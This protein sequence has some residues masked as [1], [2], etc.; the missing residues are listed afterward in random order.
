MKS[1]KL[2]SIIP[3][4]QHKDEICN[5]DCECT[6]DVKKE[7]YLKIDGTYTLEAADENYQEKVEN[8]IEDECCNYNEIIVIIYETLKMINAPYVDIF[9]YSLKLSKKLIVQKELLETFTEK[10]FE[11]NQSHNIQILQLNIDNLSAIG[12]LLSIGFNKLDNYKIKDY[13]HLMKLV[14]DAIK[15]YVNIFTDYLLDCSKK[16]K[17]PGEIKFFN[18]FETRKKKY[19]FPPEIL[20]ILNTYQNVQTIILEIDNLK[21][22]GQNLSS[23][24]FKFFELAILNFHWLLNSVKNIKFNFISKKLEKALFLRK[25]KKFDIFCLKTAFNFKPMEILF[26]DIKYLNQKCNFSS[27]LKTYK[28]NTIKSE[29]FIEDFAYGKESDVEARSEIAQKNFNL[30]EYIF[31]SFFSLNFYN[32]KNIKFE[33]VM[34]NCYITEFYVGFNEAYNFDWLKE[35][36]HFFHIFDFLLFN[37]LINNLKIFNIEFNSLD[38]RAFQKINNFLF[39]NKSITNLYISFFTSDF[40]YMPMHL[41]L[42]Y[43][44][45]FENINSPLPDK[46]LK[47]NFDENTYLFCDTKEIE[48]KILNNLFKNF[49]GNLAAFFDIIKSK[50]NLE[51]IGLDIDA[52]VNIRNQSKY[53]NSIFKFILNILFYVSKQKIKKFCLN[54]PFTI[55]DP[56]SKP[57]I[58]DLF[59]N[60]NLKNN[61]H[62]EQLT[63][64]MQFYNT[65]SITSFINTRLV[66]LNLGNMDLNTFKI[67]CNFISQNEFQ[68]SSSLKQITFSLIESINKLTDEIKIL[69]GKLFAIKIKALYSLN[70]YTGLCL[71]DKEQYYDLLKLINYNWI[72]QYI[73]TF[74]DCSD[75]IYESE[76]NNLSKL[77]CLIPI[78]W[79]DKKSQN[80]KNVEEIDYD[81]YIYLKYL[82]HKKYKPYEADKCNKSSSQNDKLD[83]IQK[84]ILFDILKYLYVSRVPSVNHEFKN[85]LF[86]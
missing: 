76:A 83:I 48:N 38:K 56:L 39:Y 41:Y 12:K 8:Y 63:L 72:M 36:S 60:I 11:V 81:V 9:D 1:T 15:N 24:D 18:F 26:N 75:N 7:K 50:K 77:K 67:L 33:L 22:E 66:I 61:Q 59:N 6:N 32:N 43:S 54:S 57:R 3:K 17:E 27:Q 4:L 30:F 85:K 28:N 82:I 71:S 53:M 79:E 23:E 62:Y 68:K 74:D 34:N 29:E 80:R 21:E 40:T 52:P 44:E 14:E 73:I 10:L 46:E 25:R 42:L 55:I 86:K 65:K 35:N 69:F 5:E 49:C 78:F 19:G 70:L 64:Q 16:S 13:G 58:D 47:M 51:E 20:I 2:E 45:S 37:N 84:K 31:I